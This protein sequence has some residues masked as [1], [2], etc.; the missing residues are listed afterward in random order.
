MT[1]TTIRRVVGGLVAA[2]V[3]AGTAAGPADAAGPACTARLV[4]GTAGSCTWYSANSY[5]TFTVAPV[6]TVT[7]TVRCWTSWGTQYTS[8][9]TVSKT[10][11]WSA[12]APQSCTLTLTAVSAGASA[13]GTAV[14]STGPIIDPGPYPG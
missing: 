2:G 10:T 12:Y 1:G 7:A 5:S 13:V 14:A 9:R 4:A 8:S 11:T 3:L 6:G